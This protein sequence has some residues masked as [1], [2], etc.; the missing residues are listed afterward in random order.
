MKNKIL[1]CACAVA[2]L[3]AF[4]SCKK[5]VDF[6]GIADD[7]SQQTLHGYFSGAELLGD[8]LVLHVAQ[9]HFNDDGTVERTVMTEGNKVS[10]A[11]VTRKFSSWNFGEY[12]DQGK[13]RYVILNPEDGS[14]PL[15]VRYLNGG[16]LEDAQPSAVDKNNKVADIATTDEAIINKKWLGNDTTY[17]KIDTVI[18][19][20]KYDSIYK[21]TG[22]KK[23]SAGNIMYDD[24]GNPLWERVLVRVDSTLVPTE[25][26]WPV[27]PKTIN[28]RRFELYRDP[29][30]FENTGKWLMI[31]KAYDMDK[32]RVITPTMDTTSTYDFH[33]SYAAYASTA[34]F[35]V[36]A[37]QADGTSE[38]F[39][40]RFD[41]KIPAVTL[42]KQ[43]LK[44]EE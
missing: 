41:A 32:N 42:D 18:D 44:L 16:I 31:M 17:H 33:W 38:L 26:K 27:A 35:V 11:P 3:S 37:V 14:E 15:T 5:Q 8:E 36:K 43:V 24:E 4:T 20:M 10:Q 2:L 40:V 19:V 12:F 21:R 30:T 34:S 13:G 25:M 23:D 39:D 9:Y 6:N 22:Y 29:V 7:V 28:V 1:L